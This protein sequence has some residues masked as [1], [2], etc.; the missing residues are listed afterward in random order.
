MFIANNFLDRGFQN[1][2]LPFQYMQHMFFLS[3]F[4]I[5]NNCI[6]RP[7]VNYYIVSL[8]GTLG[9]M[10]LHIIRIFFGHLAK[11]SPI[12][13]FFDVVQILEFVFI[14]FVFYCINIVKRKAS[15]Q[16]VLKIQSAFRVIYYKHYKMF[17]IWNWISLSLHFVLF[18]IIVSCLREFWA[19]FFYYS[20]L[21]FNVSIIHGIRIIALI[22]DGMKTWISEIKYY[23]KL[24]LELE[25]GK[26]NHHLKKLFQAYIDL[27]DAFDILRNIFKFSVK[28]LFLL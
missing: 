13:K 4:S 26:Y 19:A 6:R 9:F 2:L 20:L 25:E 10:S 12:V 5:E 22:R 15:V 17:A 8:I 21:Y 27:M 28:W 18:I 24:C 3:S 16:M 14:Y 23:G 1:I 7:T 11:Y